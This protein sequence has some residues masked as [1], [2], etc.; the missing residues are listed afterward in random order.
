M[1]RRTRSATG[2][3]GSTADAISGSPPCGAAR[4]G[5]DAQFLELERT[6]SLPGALAH[7][8]EQLVGVEW[9]DDNAADL[10]DPHPRDVSGKG[11]GHDGMADH[12][13]ALVEDFA[14]D[15]ESIHAGH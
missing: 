4:R 1:I 9:F 15:G 11:R 10:V 2:S 14:Q 12:L 13:R 7:G 3:T 5:T 6:P 8:I